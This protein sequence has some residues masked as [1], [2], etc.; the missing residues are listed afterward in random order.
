MTVALVIEVS[1]TL[2]T[3]AATPW[4]R[5]ERAW[6]ATTFAK[7]LP[8]WRRA[9]FLL[10]R[11]EPAKKLTQSVVIFARAVALLE[12]T[13]DAGTTDAEARGHPANKR[14]DV[15]TTVS[16]PERNGHQPRAERRVVV[17]D[18]CA[19]LGRAPDMIGPITL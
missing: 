4:V 13:V 3:L 2:T 18:M 7:L 9:T 19:P 12:R 6:P 1:V 10:V 15:A 5:G 17:A 16:A 8:F 14:P 11:V